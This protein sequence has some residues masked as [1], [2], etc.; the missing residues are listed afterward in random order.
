MKKLFYLLPVLSSV[1]FYGGTNG[2]QAVTSLKH[3]VVNL[4]EE[5]IG[6]GGPIIAYKDGITG[7]EGAESLSPF[8]IT[9]GDSVTHFGNRGQGPHDFIHPYVIQ[10]LDGD[11]FGTYD[12]QTQTY[13]EVTVPGKDIP[14]G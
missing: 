13:K 2:K 14:P 7:Y 5:Y 12:M 4:K 8:F 11:V 10:Y 6:M 1:A 9:R 3:S